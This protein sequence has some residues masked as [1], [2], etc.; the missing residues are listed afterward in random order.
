MLTCEVCGPIV[1]CVKVL[2]E[3]ETDKTFVESA[4]HAG[5]TRAWDPPWLLRIQRQHVT[6]SSKVFD[7]EVLQHGELH[8]ELRNSLH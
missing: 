4:C 6:G 5:G 8:G 3:P 2:Q 7:A 1:D